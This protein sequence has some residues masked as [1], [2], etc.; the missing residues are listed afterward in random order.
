VGGDFYVVSEVLHNWGDA[1]A[2]D[3]LVQCRRAMTTPAR[4]LVV[5]QVMPEGNAPSPGKL[6][7]IHMLVTNAGGRERTER[8]WRT[9]LEAADFCLQSIVPTGAAYDILEAV[10][11]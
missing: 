3:I 9:L 7:N 1:R 10:P 8:E 11:R 2:T 4:L 6:M 5:E